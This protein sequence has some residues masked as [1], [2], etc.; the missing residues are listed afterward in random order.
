MSF[1]QVQSIIVCQSSS[2]VDN[3]GLCP[4]GQSLTRIEAYV[5]QPNSEEL[6]NNN[7]ISFDDVGAFFAIGF[8]MV[9]SCYCIAKA[10]GFIFNIVR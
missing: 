1:G 4:V 10:C 6:F 3:S 9:I 5:L 7:E 2:V 8:S